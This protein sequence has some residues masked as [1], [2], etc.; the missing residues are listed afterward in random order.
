[1]N[2]NQ[3]YNNWE[4]QDRQRRQYQKHNPNRGPQYFGYN[5]RFFEGGDYPQ[6]YRQNFEGE[7]LDEDPRYSHP[8]GFRTSQDYPRR[9]P[10]QDS[11]R[12]QRRNDYN[13]NEVPAS[14]PVYGASLNYGSMGSY[15]GA[16]G[17]GSG[18]NGYSSSGWG[19]G[20]RGEAFQPHHAVYGAYRDK[21][22][23]AEG[24]NPGYD[25]SQRYGSQ[26]ADASRRSRYR[27]EPGNRRYNSG[28]YDSRY[29]IYDTSESQYN[30][31]DYGNPSRGT[32]TGS[33][34]LHSHQN[35]SPQS[36]YGSRQ[37]SH[38]R[39]GS[40]NDQYTGGT[41]DLDYGN[42]G[43]PLNEGYTY[44]AID[45]HQYPY[46]NDRTGEYWGYKTGRY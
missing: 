37:R 32:E 31:G 40:G 5:D 34:N 9:Q 43:G 7:Y 39:Q 19:S 15:G 16:Q 6:N 14:N 30:H 13:R 2:R 4:E 46:Y 20:H 26:G 17:Y 44:E 3:P 1:M 42:T 36:Y 33:F 23:F 11:D 22:S 38:S 29:E 24:E 21:N 35:E 8:K 41:G 28:E 45:R 18:R 10:W 12:Y 27:Q 25:G